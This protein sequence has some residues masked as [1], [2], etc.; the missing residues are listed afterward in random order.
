MRMRII[1]FS[2]AMNKREGTYVKVL[3]W[4]L[5]ARV[6]RI[7]PLHIYVFIYDI[8]NIENQTYVGSSRN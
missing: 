7:G 3:H 6:F 2:T 5:H 1:E 4:S 8:K